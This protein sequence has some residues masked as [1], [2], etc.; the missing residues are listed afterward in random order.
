MP[1]PT[2]A[3]LKALATRVGAALRARGWRLATAESCTGGWIAK[4]LTDQPGSSH[5]F[6]FGFVTYANEAKQAC[7]GVSAES[8]A[9]HGAVSD[10]VVEQMATGARLA[11]A[12]ELAVAVSGIAGPGGGS[13]DK[14]VG[15][16]WL[17]WAGPGPRLEARCE[18]FSGD[19]DAVRRQAVAAALAG[20]LERL[21][22][23]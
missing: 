19:R 7:L 2:D 16:V 14:P 21:D 3:G 10:E 18:Y 23:G 12:A 1:T 20:V 9:T 13:P 5:W 8:L 4:L 6:S 17:G 11:S 22:S 15:L